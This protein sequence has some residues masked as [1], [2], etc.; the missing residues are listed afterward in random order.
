VRVSASYEFGS[1]VSE[2]GARKG[3]VVDG[4]VD[5]AWEDADLEFKV[6][7]SDPAL[8]GGSGVHSCEL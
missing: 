6:D 1:V 5:G 3:E 4:L 2:Y 8:S 7:D